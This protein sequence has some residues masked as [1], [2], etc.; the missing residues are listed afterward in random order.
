M[1]IYPRTRRPQGFYVYAYLRSS[2]LT[3]Y[4][5]GKGSGDRAYVQHRNVSKKSGTWTPSNR[6]RI[7]IVEQMLSEI[8]A[9]AIERRLIAWY[10]RKDIETGILHNRTEGGD[11]TSGRIVSESCRQSMSAKLKGRIS[12]TKGL[13]AWNKGIP[14]TAEAKLQASASLSGR[15]TWNKGIPAS[16]ES[17]IKRKKAQSG[18]AKPKITCPHCQKIGGAP[19]MKRH[20]FDNCKNKL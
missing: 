10:G 20:H 15:P 7:V 18:I 6:A 13:V 14:M 19:A 17:N 5:I 2:D 1:S 16:A 3:P 8:G 12:P 4:Y 11:G 9:L